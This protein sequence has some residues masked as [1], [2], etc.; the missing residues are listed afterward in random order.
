MASPGILNQ[1]S[2]PH[3]DATGQGRDE[4]LLFS[5]RTEDAL[6]SLVEPGRN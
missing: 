3:I 2:C 1:E 5:Q 4:W 6:M